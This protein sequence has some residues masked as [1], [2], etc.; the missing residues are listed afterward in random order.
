MKTFVM[1]VCAS[2]AILQC[3]HRRNGNGRAEISRGLHLKKPIQ[4]AIFVDISGTHLPIKD[5]HYRD[6]GELKGTYR[7]WLQR[8]VHLLRSRKM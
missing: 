3:F 6:R 5:C 8:G 4:S 1:D 7:Q 2:V